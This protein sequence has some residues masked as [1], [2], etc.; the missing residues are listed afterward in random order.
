MLDNIILLTDS[1]KVSHYRQYPPGA[2]RVYS[3]FESR[4]GPYNEIVFFGLQYF[5]KKYLE[6]PVVTEDKI[7]QAFD[8]FSM[9]FGDEK[10]FNF[11]GWKR[12]LDVHGGRLPLLIK[13]VPEGTPV[14]PHNVLMT[15]ENTDPELPWLTNYLE[16]LLVQVWYPTTVATQS[17]EMKRIILDNLRVSGT[18]ELIDYKLH[19]FGYRGSTS[20]ESAALGA[21]AHLVNFRG[22]DT[23][24]GI[25]LARRYYYEIM[26]G[27]SIPAAEHSTI[28]SWGRE[29]EADAYKNMLSQYPTGL[30]AVV[31][32]SYDIY[33]ACSNIWGSQLH[34]EV[35]KR[36]GT[37]VIRPDSGDP[38]TVV[39]QV[40]QILG[41]KFGYEENQKGYKV[42]DPHVRVI[43]GDG[44]DIHEIRKILNVMLSDGWSGDNIAFGSGGG[45]LQKV[46]RDTCKFAFK[47]SS[48]EVDDVWLDVYKQPVTDPGKNSKRGRF[49]LVHAGNGWHTVQEGSVD[50]DMLVEKF[51]DGQVMEEQTFYGVRQYANL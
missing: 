1:Y 23:F 51:R 9:H 3:F 7:N 34:D 42:L 10:A 15:V 40:L 49:N 22:T 17:R 29:H 27:N 20:P 16:T 12:I 47:C 37:L 39:L 46:D 41:E 36:D 21:A 11:D 45:L 14:S 8:L 44:I 33:N 4:G 18:P 13:S 43:Q 35:L 5:L 50:V 6:G 2:T 38:S 25:E 28:T 30:V 48:I 26:A 19:D 24:A 31:S 32:D